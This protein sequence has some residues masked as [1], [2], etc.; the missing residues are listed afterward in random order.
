MQQ[1]KV[2]TTR[3]QNWTVGTNLKFWF[4]C[5][6]RTW[7]MM[8]WL[9][10]GGAGHLLLNVISRKVWKEV[11]SDRHARAWYHILYQ[12]YRVNELKG[13]TL[14]Q[15]LALQTALI[16]FRWNTWLMTVN[17]DSN[18]VSWDTILKGDPQILRATTQVLWVA[19]EVLSVG[20][21]VLWVLLKSCE[22]RLK[23]HKLWLKPHR[24][25]F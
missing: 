7:G 21:Q 9:W 3:W 5:M 25:Q 1:S 17:H 10:R 8:I 24:S 15:G 6:H 11:S 16:Y 14:Q 12:L 20:T 13:N 18:L 19:T 2:L 4:I 22:P 23:S